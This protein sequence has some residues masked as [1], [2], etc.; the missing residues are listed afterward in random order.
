ILHH[1]FVD[2]IAIFFRLV[3]DPREHDDLV[4]LQLHALRE[5]RDLP[6]RN[7][8]ADALDI[9]ERAVALPQLPG[10]ACPLAILLE[11]LFRNW[12]DKSIYVAHCFSSCETSYAPA[13]RGPRARASRCTA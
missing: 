7:I 13:S 11:L 8:I 2:A 9:L 3:E 4:V 10:F 6:R 1:E 5:R 12:S